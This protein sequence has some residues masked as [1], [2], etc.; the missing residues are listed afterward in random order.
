MI[1]QSGSGCADL[2]DAFF[3]DT[4]VVEVQLFQ[5][6]ELRKPVGAGVGDVGAVEAQPL[7]LRQAAERLEALVADVGVVEVQIG[8]IGEAADRRPCSC[9]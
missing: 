9:R 2:L 7:E 1:S 4:R 6:P 3:R 5:L 8:E